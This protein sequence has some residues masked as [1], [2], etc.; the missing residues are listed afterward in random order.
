ML[1]KYTHPAL[2]RTERELE[3]PS[4]LVVLLLL[5][6]PIQLMELMPQSSKDDRHRPSP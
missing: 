4:Q 2:A 1:V 6:Q 5:Q 3:S